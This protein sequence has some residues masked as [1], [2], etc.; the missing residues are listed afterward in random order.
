MNVDFQ[1]VLTSSSALFLLQA[2]NV[3]AVLDKK[4]R[5]LDKQLSDWRQKCEELMSEVESCQK[6]SRQH[7]AELFK[8][9]TAYEESM[10]QSE[11]LRR[12]NKALQ[13]NTDTSVTVSPLRNMFISNF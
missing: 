11:A 4:Q 5:M 3:A 8:L 13:G 12:E 10:E 1:K 9:K 6:E 7:A 2:N